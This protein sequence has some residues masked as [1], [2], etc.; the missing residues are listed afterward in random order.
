MIKE[1]KE[2][3]LRGNVIDLAIGVVIG[4][5]FTAIVTSLVEGL[6]TPLVSWILSLFGNADAFSGLVFEPAKNVVFDFGRVITAIITF[7]ITAFVLFLIVKAVNKL[8]NLK[9]QPEE[10]EVPE[11]TAEDYLEEIRDLL[12]A[13]TPTANTVDPRPTSLDDTIR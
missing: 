13:Q 6:L 12:K 11:I 5:A 2:F 3:I 1:F 7:L 9:Q 4:S 10:D 8:R